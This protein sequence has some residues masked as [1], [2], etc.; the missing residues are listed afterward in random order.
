MLILRCVHLGELPS[1]LPGA[2]LSGSC[3]SCEA[4]AQS[5]V[6]GDTRRNNHSGGSQVSSSR[7]SSCS[8]Y[9]SSQSAGAWML[10][11]QGR[12]PAQLGPP[13]CSSVPTVLGPPL[14]HLSCGE[15]RILLCV[16][17]ALGSGACAAGI[18]LQA[19]QPPPRS[20]CLSPSELLPGPALLAAAL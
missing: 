9:H 19:P 1:P 20:H 18:A 11:G 14:L 16:P 3:L 4:P 12:W 15:H 13:S 17:H 6:Q 7:V 5:Q 2:W 8:N 10:G